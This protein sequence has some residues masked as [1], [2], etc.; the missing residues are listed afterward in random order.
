MAGS[1]AAM[2]QYIMKTDHSTNTAAGA[3]IDVFI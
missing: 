1:R 3:K 2:S